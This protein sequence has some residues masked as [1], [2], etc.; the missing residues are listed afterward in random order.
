MEDIFGAHRAYD[1]GQRVNMGID[2]SLT[3]VKRTCR[4]FKGQQLEES[5]AI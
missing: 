1:N 3:C 4:K 5:G 2:G